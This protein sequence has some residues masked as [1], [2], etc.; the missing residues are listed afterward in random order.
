LIKSSQELLKGLDVKEDEDEDEDD[1]IKPKIQDIN[2]IQEEVKIG[3]DLDE[4]KRAK[5]YSNLCQKEIFVIF[6]VKEVLNKQNLQL[7]MKPE[8]TMIQGLQ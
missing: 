7:L 1:A 6:L 8:I 2:E 3:K 5:I 4:H